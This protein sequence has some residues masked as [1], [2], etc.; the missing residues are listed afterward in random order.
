[1]FKELEDI[2]QFAGEPKRRW[3]ADEYFDLIIWQDESEEIVEFELCYDKSKNQRTV[4]WEKSTGYTHH[5]VDDGDRPGKRKASPVLL[6]D[7]YCDFGTIARLFA[8]AR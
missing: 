7:G 8:L 5:R 3:F 4:R 1:M 2:K 6:P